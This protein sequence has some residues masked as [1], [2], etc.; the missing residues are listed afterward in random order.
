MTI[1]ANITL[2]HNKHTKKAT[3]PPNLKHRYFC[4]Q[5]CRTS[6]YDSPRLKTIIFSSQHTMQ[7]KDPPTRNFTSVYASHEALYPGKAVVKESEEWTTAKELCELHLRKYNA[8]NAAFKL[9]N[10]TYVSAAQEKRRTRKVE[11]K[12]PNR[13]WVKHNLVVG[14]D[15][16][17]EQLWNWKERFGMDTS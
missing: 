9:L 11:E 4:E 7:R 13:R 14:R 5:F 15:P 3:I 16:N 8:G 6:A 12:K 2:Q 1:H 10:P 17:E